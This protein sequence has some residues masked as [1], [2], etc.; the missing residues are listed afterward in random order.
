MGVKAAHL[1]DTSAI[2]AHLLRENGWDTVERCLTPDG[3]RAAVSVI[4]WVEFQLYINRSDYPEADGTRIIS[5][6]RKALGSPL[7]IDEQTGET[8]VALKPGLPRGFISPIS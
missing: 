6:Y 1:L 2:L 3:G 5:F 8:A 4:S 7:P